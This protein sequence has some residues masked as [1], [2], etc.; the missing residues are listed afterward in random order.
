MVQMDPRGSLFR[1]T[2][3]LEHVLEHMSRK[4]PKLYDFYNPRKLF[5]L[6]I[7]L[8]GEKAAQTWSAQT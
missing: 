4:G 6:L 7:D 3:C 5:P 8:G 2:V 1:F